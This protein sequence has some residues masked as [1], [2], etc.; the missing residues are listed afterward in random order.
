MEIT[1]KAFAERAKLPVETIQ[2]AVR[3]GIL[4]VT[5]YGSLILI[6]VDR[7]ESHF[8]ALEREETQK[9]VK[10]VQAAVESRISGRQNYS[11]EKTFHY[12]SRRDEEPGEFLTVEGKRAFEKAMVRGQIRIFERRG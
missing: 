12:T 11:P 2:E 4:P 9:R 5:Q 3:L 8:A 7:I 10:P 6:D 1:I